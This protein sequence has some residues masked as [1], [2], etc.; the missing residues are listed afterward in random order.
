VEVGA[1]DGRTGSTTFAFEKK[2]WQC[3]L[4]EPM[5]ALAEAIRRHRNCIV[6]NCAASTSE[7]EATFFVAENVEEMSTLDLT[8]GRLEWIERV[9][10]HVTQITAQTRR[11]DDL[12][13]EA[14]FPRID[15]ITIDVE[16]HELEVLRGFSLE[17]YRPRIVIV[18]DNSLHRDHWPRK[19]SPVT[20]YLAA[21]EYVH[22]NRTG[23]NEWYARA[24][25]HELVQ[26][27][28]IRRF[29]RSKT[30]QLWRRRQQRVA[31]RIATHVGRFVPGGIKRRLR[32]LV[33]CGPPAED[34]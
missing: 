28:R 31:N 12:L 22:F 23:V 13:H 3:L 32:A 16:G 4:V 24:G 10:G 8:P 18:E 26:P 19:R 33:S 25:D 14:D 5:P 1:Y 29:E 7:G 20:D 11:L 9:G 30:V 6:A 17:S 34:P 27:D 2:G 15:F 21:R